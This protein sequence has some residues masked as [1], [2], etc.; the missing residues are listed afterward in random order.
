[1]TA[2]RYVLIFLLPVAIAF[3]VHFGT[4][5]LR[6]AAHQEATG[7]IDLA[8]SA[9]TGRRAEAYDSL[10][11]GERFNNSSV[12]DWVVAGSILLGCVI[13][14]ILVPARSSMGTSARFLSTMAAGF[15]AAKTLIGF[16]W[17]DWIEFGAWLAGGL[18]CAVI[19]VALRRTQVSAERLS[20]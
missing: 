2:L 7:W 1:M 16:G 6:F 10:I 9:D 13:S 17:M 3:L 11:S 15:V 5:P 18:V 20:G 12:L 8:L 4:A 14:A 19:I